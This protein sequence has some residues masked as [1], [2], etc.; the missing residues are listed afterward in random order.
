MI[1]VSTQWEDMGYP[2]VSALWHD[3]MLTCKKPHCGMWR[4]LKSWVKRF[5]ELHSGSG[6]KAYVE[7]HLKSWVKRFL[8]LHV[9]ANEAEVIFE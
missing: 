1:K 6:L 7:I 4:G 5:L 8:E 3:S 9:Y 2:D